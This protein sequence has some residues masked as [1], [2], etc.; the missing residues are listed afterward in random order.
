MYV[1]YVKV[2]KVNPD[3]AQTLLERDYKGFGS[4]VETSNGVIEIKRGHE[5]YN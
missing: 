4:N 1:N 5:H 2:E 3:I